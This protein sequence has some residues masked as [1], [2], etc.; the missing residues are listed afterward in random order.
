MLT[1][2]LSFSSA[3]AQEFPKGWIFPLELGQGAVTA[4][5]HTPDLYLGS[6][7]FAPQ[8]TLIKGRLRA[9]AAIG[10][11]YTNKRFYGTAGPRLALLLTDQP[12]V[13]YSTVLN[14]Q[15]VAEHLWGTK[16]QRLAGGGLTAEVGQ[17]GSLSLKTLRDYHLNAWWLYASLGIN[18]F[19]KKPSENPFEGIK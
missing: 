17:L 13:L 15:L 10:G 5:D 16:E 1:G 4:F 12:K 2:S 19:Q 3:A 11:A 8:Y 14:I 9:G 6:L 7:T 18:L